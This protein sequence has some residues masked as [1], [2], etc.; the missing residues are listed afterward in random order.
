MRILLITCYF[1]ISTC[2]S[3]IVDAG[4]G[5]TLI[6]DNEEVW[7]VGRNDH[8]QLGTGNYE[9]KDIPVNTGFKDIVTISRGYD[10]SMAINESSELFVW[11]NNRFGQLG[12]SNDNNDILSPIKLQ[13]NIR[14]SQCEGGY[15]HSIFLDIR[16]KV[17]ST[18]FNENGELGNMNWDDTQELVPVL[19]SDSVQLSNISGIS[20]VGSHTLALDSNGHVYS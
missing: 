5:H 14:F 17:W 13:T 3:Q 19:N 10:H 11:G 6:L 2:F 16:G 20:S 1:G 9:G 4:N 7:C 12:I 15:D 18:G 8:G